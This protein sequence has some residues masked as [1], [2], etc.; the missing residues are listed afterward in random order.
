[1]NCHQNETKSIIT[2]NNSN[3]FCVG[4]NTRGGGLFF[5][6]GDKNN[7]GSLIFG[8]QGVEESLVMLLVEEN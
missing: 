4:D 1:M 8:L 6:I 7:N 2:E 3:A 5:S